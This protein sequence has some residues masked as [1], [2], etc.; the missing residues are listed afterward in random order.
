MCVCVFARIYLVHALKSSKP[1]K[2]QAKLA[3][4][5]TRKCFIRTISYKECKGQSIK[6]EIARQ[7]LACLTMRNSLK[8]EPQ[9]LLPIFKYTPERVFENRVSKTFR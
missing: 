8:G 4:E 2:L 1:S 7:R 9:R 3:V 5:R 6:F